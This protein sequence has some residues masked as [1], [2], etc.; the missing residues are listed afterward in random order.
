MTE[1]K[2][3][4]RLSVW[5]LMVGLMCWFGFAQMALAG[6]EKSQE[7]SKPQAVASPGAATYVGAETCKGCHEQQFKQLEGTQHFKTTFEKGRGEAWHGCES[8]HGPGSAHVEGGGDKS[9]IVTFNG[10]SQK[11]ISARCMS[12]HETNAEHMNFDRSAHSKSGVGCTTCHS[13]HQPKETQY[14]LVNKQ[15]DLCYS[16]HGQVKA[17]FAKPFRHRVNEGLISCSDCHNAHG[18]RPRQLRASPTQ[19]AVC[20]KCHS[21]KKGPFVF[22]HE[23]VK[24]EGCQAC[25]TPHGSTHPRLLTRPTV[26]SMCL[27]CHAGIPNGPHPQSTKSQACTM[28]HSQIHGSNTSNVFFR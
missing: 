27:E 7:Q 14:L 19:D 21:D 15:T 18:S 2:M 16:C 28:C 22:E 10:M 26:N 8:C 3:F 24:A 23:V 9:K 20:Y 12:C 17:D 25:H 5:T 1:F 6:Q 11:D 4:R 13:V